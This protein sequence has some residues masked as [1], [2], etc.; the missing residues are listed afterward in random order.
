MSKAI[1]ELITPEILLKAALDTATK[2]THEPDHAQAD[3]L[4]RQALC[5]WDA[6]R[7]ARLAGAP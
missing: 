2:A 7:R 6:A 5:L 4:I 3:E 1:H